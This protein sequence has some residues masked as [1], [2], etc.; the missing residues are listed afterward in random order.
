[1]GM[2]SEA[3]WVATKGD[4]ELE[5]PRATFN[6][7]LREAELVSA[8]NDAITISAPTAYA[9]DWLDY[10][11]RDNIQQTLSKYL[12]FMPQIHFII[13]TNKQNGQSA[14]SAEPAITTPLLVSTAD[15]P[16]EERKL[17]PN[18]NPRYTFASFVVGNNNRLAHAAALSVSEQPGQTYNPLF[19]YGGVGLGKT[20]LLHAIG[21]RCAEN[22]LSVCY[23]S[24]EQ[25]TNDLIKAIRN[26]TTS[27][28]RELY[29]SPD[30]LLIDDIQFIAGKESTQEELF[31]TFNDLHSSGRQLIIS[32]DRPPKA[33]VLLEERLKSRFEW[34]LMADIHLPD[35]ETRMAILQSKSEETSN[36]IPTSVLET[37]AHHVRSNIRELEGALNKVIAYSNLYNRPITPE[38]VN[39]ALSDV[40]RPAE[41]LD[42]DY[43]INT[44][45]DYYNLSLEQLCSKGRNRALSYPRQIAMYLCRNETDASLPQIGHALG[46]RDHTTIIHGCAKIESQLHTDEILRRDLLELKAKLYDSSI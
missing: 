2:N 14:P 21:H 1:M 3:A 29:R 25:F 16:F 17:A 8:E 46:N 44:V 22:N 4:L 19:I 7:W 40:I 35:Q 38:I 30:V 15:T 36:N 11:L 20:H 28:F 26:Q 24:S 18:L 39:L 33:M 9:R 45:V 42:I 27:Q 23:V 5:L 10:R 13:H 43:V 34:G 41:K 6:T 32:S 37:I 12:G 31:H